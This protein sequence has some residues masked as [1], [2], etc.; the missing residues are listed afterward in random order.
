MTTPLE[1]LL[2]VT[3]DRLHRQEQR[4][5]V[6]EAALL[7][8]Q[9]TMPASRSPAVDETPG[10]RIA[11]TPT[12]RPKRDPD[13]WPPRPVRPEPSP[14][15]ATS[16]APPAVSPAAVLASLDDVVWSVSPDGQFVFF[17][18]GAV[19]RLYGVTEHELSDGRGRWLDSVPADDRERLRAS[20]ARLPDT[21]GFTL[22]HRVTHSTGDF[23][24]VVTRGKLVRDRDGRPLRVDG[25]TTDV[26]RQARTRNAIF[27]VLNAIGAASGSE[28]FAKLTQ[29]ICAACN[30]RAAIIVE[31]HASEPN[32]A[33]AVASWIGGKHVEP[34]VFPAT[35]PLLR[36]LLSGGRILAPTLARSRF[37]TDSLLLQLRAEG[38]V[39]EP[40]I[41][42]C[43]KLLGFVALAD[44][45]PLAVEPDSRTILKSLAP[46]V[47]VELTRTH[48]DSE[49]L[50]L[51]AKFAG[52]DRR[53]QAAETAL[54]NAAH[55]A[56]VGR[57]ATGLAHD[58]NNLLGVIAGN[59]DLILE[60]LPDG[61]ARRETVDVI[62]RTAQNIGAMNRRLMSVGRPGPAYVTPL[63][64]APAIRTLEPMLSRLIGKRTSLDFDL[65]PG[66]PVISADATQFD[67]VI[68]NLVL[69]A[70]DA[71][72][73][74]KAV[75]GAI[76]I[77]ATAVSIEENRLGWPP[78]CPAGSYVAITVADNGC[79]MSADVRARMF[80]RYFTTKGERGTGLGL[81]TVLE[82]VTAARGHIEVESDP[83]WGTQIRV[84]W[85]AIT[86]MPQ[87]RVLG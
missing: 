67:R 58:F 25:T 53:A 17:V 38:F 32:S 24:W 48:D 56:G 78:E 85:P 21:S 7:E 73:G 37:P 83:A 62:A 10:P 1:D 34:F 31:P 66:V 70:R 57:M 4:T 8:S 72:E 43:G 84:Y 47:A 33:R 15:A 69:N 20:L 74:T 29:A 50:A 2:R 71:V 13:E 5:A 22:E 18:G 40:L 59:A 12:A 41:A 86:E 65:A 35:T 54:H 61:D 63:D 44:D 52:A 19:E 77:G 27:D 28:F 87:L 49:T 14:T 11:E 23:R 39:A 80:D 79:G 3:L 42:A 16:H 75:P 9:P 82:I 26:T 76:R 45:R 6:L 36:E 46:R 60:T 68:L 30:I 81:A 64:T 51:K 55:L